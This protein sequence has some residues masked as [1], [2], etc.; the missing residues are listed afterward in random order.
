M[1]FYILGDELSGFKVARL[2]CMVVDSS[3]CG[4][5]VQNASFGDLTF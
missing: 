2:L 1:H 3:Q 4:V 5:L